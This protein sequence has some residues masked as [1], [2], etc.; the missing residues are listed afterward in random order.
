MMKEAENSNLS[1]V[2]EESK[3]WLTYNRLP[4]ETSYSRYRFICFN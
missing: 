2:A 4:T 1:E 3:V